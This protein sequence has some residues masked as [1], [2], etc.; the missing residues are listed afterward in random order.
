MKITT[1][2]N[3]KDLLKRRQEV[4][5]RIRD[6]MPSEAAALEAIDF[7]LQV[8]EGDKSEEPGPYASIKRGL[9]AL[10]THLKSNGGPMDRRTLVTEVIQSGWNHGD[11]LAYAKLWDVIRHQ[12]AGAPN[13]V[14]VKRK[15]GKVALAKGA[16][17]G[18]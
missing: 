12:W 13:P 18:D 14:L 1:L 9:D 4:I 5:E 7:A 11:P 6:K 3:P 2:G 17:A 8:A 10:V 15:D 16:T